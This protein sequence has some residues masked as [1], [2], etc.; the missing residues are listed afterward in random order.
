MATIGTAKSGANPKAS[1][2]KVQ[3]IAGCTAYTVILRPHQMRLI[4]TTLQHEI[5][6]QPPDRIVSKRGH[7]SGLQSK[8]S[9]QATSDVV[10]SAALPHVE[11]TRCSNSN[12]AGVEPQHYLTE[13]HQIPLALILRPHGKTLRITGSFRHFNPSLRLLKNRLLFYFKSAIATGSMSSYA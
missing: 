1:F 12:I 2:G 13:T 11:L 6:E 9:S 5:F 3:P 10:F 7:D 8:A 4:H